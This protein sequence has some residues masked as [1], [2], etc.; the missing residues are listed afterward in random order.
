M[1]ILRGK[2][3]RGRHYIGI[4]AQIGDGY[5]VGNIAFEDGRKAVSGITSGKILFRHSVEFPLLALSGHAAAF[6]LQVQYLTA[7]GVNHFTIVIIDLG[8]QTLDRLDEKRPIGAL[9]DVSYIEIFPPVLDPL[10]ETFADPKGREKRQCRMQLT[11]I[12]YIDDLTDLSATCA[13][14]LRTLEVA[15]DFKE[16][17][18]GDHARMPGHFEAAVKEVILLIAAVHVDLG[19]FELQ[20]IFSFLV[21]LGDNVDAEA[22]GI[23]VRIVLDHP[24]P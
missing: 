16:H 10:K 23:P 8:N 11:V 15:N 9:M 21:D 14:I 13:P 20:G 1:R 24:F 4:F 19:L 3:V 18:I 12:G 6:H 17:A 5:G 2:L 22:K 7:E